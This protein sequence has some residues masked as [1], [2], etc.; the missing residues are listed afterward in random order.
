MYFNGT[1][2]WGG[3]TICYI[4]LFTLC[5][6]PCWPGLYVIFVCSRYVIHHVDLV[7]MLYLFVHVMLSTLLTWLMCVICL[8]TLCYPPYWPGLYVI[9]VCSRYVIHHVDLVY[10]LYLFVHVMLSTML[11][12]FICYICLFTLCYPPCWPG[13][14]VIF[15]CSRY[16]IH[17]VD[18]VY[19]VYLFV[20]VMLSTL[21]TWLM[22]VI[23]LFTLCYPPCWP[24]LYGIFVCSRYVICYICL[25]TLCYPPCWPGLYVIF[26]CSRYVIHHVD[27]V[28]MLYLFVHVM[29]STLLTWLM[30]V[31]CLFTLCYPP[32]WPGLY[33]I[34]VCSRY[35]IHHVDLVYMLYLFVHVMLSTLLTWFI[36]YI[37]LFT[38]CYPPCWPCLDV[39]FVCLGVVIHPVDLVM[40]IICLFRWC[41]SFCW[42]GLCVL[43]VCLRVVIHPVDL[44]MC[45]I[46]LFRWCYSFC[47]PGLCVL[48]VCLS[49]V[50]HPVD[51]V[52]CVIC[53]FKWC[54]PPC[55]PGLCVLFVCLG[56]VIHSVDLVYVCYLFV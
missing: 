9:F 20:H 45:I 30:C 47:W 16:V 36:W 21:L 48:F 23:C 35:V 43:F 13:L 15:V 19:M 22:C 34:F 37:C 29:L 51:L 27:L 11:T 46:C 26:V 44:V 32:C 6:P 2:I 40:C 55:W 50:I 14:Y 39:V 42:P 31:I 4:C 24:G 54:Y 52:M 10:M 18:L 8:F 33:V 41:Y 25:F 28:Y 12:W 49:V 7:Y 38:L 3:E 1:G 53:L 5:Y 56:D 17:H